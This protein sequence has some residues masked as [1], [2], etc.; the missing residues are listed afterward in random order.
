MIEVFAG[1]CLRREAPRWRPS[2]VRL[3][4]LVPVVL[5]WFEMA[6]I[7]PD[8]LHPGAGGV[9]VRHLLWFAALVILMGGVQFA[10]KAVC[11]EVSSEMR[12]IVRLTGLDAKLLL[13]TKTLACWWTIGWSL[14]LLL[15]ALMFAI[16]LGGVSPDQL[17]VGAYGLV[18]LTALTGGFGMLAGVLTVDAKNPEKM[19]ASATMLGLVFYN[20]SFV[21]FS[22]MLL[23]GSWL[24]SG[25]VSSSLNLLCRRIALC[26]PVVSVANALRGPFLFTVTDPGYWLHFLTA[27]GCAALATVA[28][29]LRFRSGVSTADATASDG[30]PSLQGAAV[31]DPFSDKPSS[32]SDNIETTVGEPV[33]VT[34]GTSPLPSPAA[35]ATRLSDAQVATRQAAAAVMNPLSARRPRC[36]DRPFFWK[37]V[38]VLS[39]ER[40]W[41]NMW[42]LFYFAATAGVLFVGVVSTDHADRYRVVVMSI[43]AIV[44]AAIILSLRFDA[45]LTAEFRDRTWGSLMLLPVDPCDLLWIKLRAALY[46]QRF[47]GLPLGAALATLLLIGP[48]DALVATGMVA[49]IALLVCGL[50]CQMSCVNQLLGKAWWVGPC[51]AVGFIA[52]LV[53]SFAIW[54]NA[55]LWAGFLLTAVFLTVLVLIVQSTCVVP[56]ARNWVET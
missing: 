55:G 24:F 44:V 6:T 13:W 33:G 25:E 39:D 46:E 38:Y 40:K 15:P 26:A 29:E 30:L 16:T 34:P 1:W 11:W 47:A 14:L 53:A 10:S 56:L 3:A 49:V 28:M 35:D 31:R 4:F 48:G 36:S 37:D 43:F 52:A 45:L 20:V 7:W 27:T 8:L 22:Q 23:W 2:V 50:L 41:L 32:T 54:L 17:V 12:D 21:L 18:V 9:A 42:T 5:V 51:Q 19:A